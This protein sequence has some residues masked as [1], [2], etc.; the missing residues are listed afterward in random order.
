M[1]CCA[2]VAAALCVFPQWLQAAQYQL[3]YTSDQH[4]GISRKDFRG[5]K[6]VSSEVVNAAMAEAI[7]S[8]PQTRLPND[9]GVR[10]G[11]LV[12]WADFVIST[13]DIANRMEGTDPAKTPSAAACWKQFEAHY[14]TK[15]LLLRRDGKTAEVLVVPGNHDVT[16]SVGFYRPMTPQKDVSSS[17]AMY[18]RALGQ[19]KSA[20][21]FQPVK[22]KVFLRRDLDG[23]RLLLV[24]M[25]PDSVTRQ[26]L[27]RQFDNATPTLLF[28][29]DQP[30]VEAKHLRNPNGD[31]SI[32]ATDKFENLLSDVSSVNSVKAIPAREHRELAAF[33]KA[34]PVKAYFH[35]NENFNE[36]YT[37]GGPDDIFALPIFRVDSPMKG[38]KSSK[39]ERLLSFQVVSIDTDTRTMT[40]REALWNAS[41]A[42]S[43]IVWGESRTIDLGQ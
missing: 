35:G 15:P 9:N 29:H 21:E 32:N 20:A 2:L 12:S 41:A 17:L 43:G 28:T 8:L 7:M 37:W 22:D 26:W 40:V 5:R 19:S 42:P 18:N 14:F 4:Y 38:N 30:D 13:G 31:G 16:N 25:W 33:L 1:V 10:S 36:F 6:D 27:S 23:L 24:E 34:S 3:V 11:E 39:D